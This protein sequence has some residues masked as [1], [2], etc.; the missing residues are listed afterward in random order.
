MAFPP[1]VTVK[2][3]AWGGSEGYINPK[4]G[5]Q[6]ARFRTVIQ[7]VPAPAGADAGR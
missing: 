4:P 7:F 3:Y 1:G 5:G 6:P 2:D